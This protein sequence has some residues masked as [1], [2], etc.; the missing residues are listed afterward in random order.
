MELPSMYQRLGLDYVSECCRPLSTRCSRAV[1]KSNASQL[2]T[3]L[4]QV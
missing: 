4:A 1:A 3:Q 2:I